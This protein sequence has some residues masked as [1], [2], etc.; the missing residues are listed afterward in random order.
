LESEP[1]GGSD[2][3]T[4]NRRQRENAIIRRPLGQFGGKSDNPLP[5]EKSIPPVFLGSERDTKHQE[6][7]SAAA[8]TCTYSIQKI[9]MSQEQ[10]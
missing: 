1:G 2:W 10:I 3:V 8:A 9:K 7:Q 4:G 6:I 5:H